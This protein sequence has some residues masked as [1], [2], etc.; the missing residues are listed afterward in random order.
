MVKIYTS[1]EYICITGP[2]EE[3]IIAFEIAL[4]NKVYDDFLY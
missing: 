4:S 1:N 2:H 3:I